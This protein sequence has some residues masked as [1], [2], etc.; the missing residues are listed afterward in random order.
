MASGTDGLGQ[1]ERVEPDA[2][3][4]IEPIGPSR[5]PEIGVERARLGLL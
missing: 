2:A 1:P 3:A 5:Q 4:D